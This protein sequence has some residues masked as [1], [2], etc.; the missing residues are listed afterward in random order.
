MH[1][2]SMLGLWGGGTEVNQWGVE[3][4][5]RRSLTCHFFIWFVHGLE[6]LQQGG[7]GDDAG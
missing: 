6:L 7:G 4:C 5:D 3:R 1:T 2:R